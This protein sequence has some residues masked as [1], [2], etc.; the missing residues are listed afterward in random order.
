MYWYLVHTKPKQERCALENLERQG[1]QCFLP[2]LCIEKLR[3]GA[4]VLGEE[5]LF[6]RY[7]FIRLGQD[8][9]SRSW[10]PIRSTRGVSRI[11]S[12]GAEPA[13][14]E[15]GLVAALQAQAFSRGGEPERLFR[16]GDRV[17]LTEAPFVGIEGVYQL[18]E[19]ER[20]VMVLIE[21][22]SKSVTVRVSPASL[23]RVG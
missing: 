16:P 18:A 20:R 7:L 5:P 13:R 1:Y 19:G 17:L 15:E 8:H 9:S 3:N 4:V 23:R 6:P 22:L 11:V 2:L 12:F 21:M 14:V 10:A